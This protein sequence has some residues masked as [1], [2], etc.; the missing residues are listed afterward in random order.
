MNTTDL[1][2]ADFVKSI[3]HGH[4]GVMR[5]HEMGH[6]NKEML[7]SFVRYLSSARASGEISDQEFTDYLLRM[8]AI[9]VEN[10]VTDQ[11]QNMLSSR[12][13]ELFLAAR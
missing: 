8:S 9:F 3:S 2:V 1:A 10:E 4:S 7:K 5:S 6:L 11:V 13:R 12:I